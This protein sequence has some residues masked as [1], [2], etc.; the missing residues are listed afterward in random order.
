VVSEL[1]V[2]RDVKFI[3]HEDL[4]FKK[5]SSS[6][7]EKLLLEFHLQLEVHRTFG[8]PAKS[9]T[10]GLR[11]FFRRSPCPTPPSSALRSSLVSNSCSNKTKSGRETISLFCLEI[12][13]HNTKTERK[14]CGGRRTSKLHEMKKEEGKYQLPENAPSQSF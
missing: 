6:F 2:R 9:V 10:P 7:F 1:D 11:G 5:N 3:P 14:I 4:K 13:F 12:L 8:S